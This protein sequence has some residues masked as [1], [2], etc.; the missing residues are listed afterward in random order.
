M[1]YSEVSVLLVRY[2]LDVAVISLIVAAMSFVLKRTVLEER[3][4]AVM[5]IAYAAGV[6]IYGVYICIAEG[7]ALFAF[8]N[9]ASVMERGLAIGT[10]ATLICAALEKFTCGDG[11]GLDAIEALIDSLVPNEKLKE[12]AK[13][14]LAAI[15]EE[16][17]ELAAALAEI[18][19]A[20]AE[21]ADE[22]EIERAVQ[23]ICA[24]F[25]EADREKTTTE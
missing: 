8:M 3:P 15:R 6:L 13:A 4:R 25:E 17:E 24:A 16:A 19:A 11:D 23:E 1:E 7:D 9:F 21:S 14:L 22:A 18:L 5:L 2:G 10:I 12:C 20:Y